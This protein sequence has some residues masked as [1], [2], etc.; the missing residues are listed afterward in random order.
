M[1]SESRP[2]GYYSLLHTPRDA[3]KQYLALAYIARYESI[4]Y[5]HGDGTLEELE[6][7]ISIL[8]DD[9]SRK[10]YDLQLEAAL[11]QKAAENEEFLKNKPE[12]LKQ[13]QALRRSWVIFDFIVLGIFIFTMISQFDPAPNSY[14]T[15]SQ[16]SYSTQERNSQTTM[17]HSESKTTPKAEKPSSRSVRNQV[18]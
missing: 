4:K 13:E 14:K 16:T 11:K 8:G 12:V 1:I 2:Y 9:A 17:D 15:E 18:F 5:E 6:K 10:S 7:A 3:N